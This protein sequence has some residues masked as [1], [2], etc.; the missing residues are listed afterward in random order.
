MYLVDSDV[1]LHALLNTDRGAEAGKFLDEHREI[2]TT[3]FN[4]MEISSVL[5]RKYRW[6][7]E[8]IRTARPSK[9]ISVF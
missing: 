4:L 7:S 2:Y 3:I 9:R 5:A 8:E 1:F 6:K